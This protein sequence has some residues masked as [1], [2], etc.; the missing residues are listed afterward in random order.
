MRYHLTQA[1]FTESG[2]YSI[3]PA[4]QKLDKYRMYLIALGALNRLFCEAS[5][6]DG[7]AGTTYSSNRRL[8]S[9]PNGADLISFQSGKPHFLNNNEPF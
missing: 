7:T 1:H 2:I 9:R 4:L 6:P 3:Q 5:S 8:Q